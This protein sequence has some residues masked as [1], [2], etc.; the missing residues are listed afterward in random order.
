MTSPRILPAFAALALFASLALPPVLARAAQPDGLHSFAELYRLSV[1]ADY[2]VTEAAAAP[3]P[4]G[5]VPVSFALPQDR[6]PEPS[7][8]AGASV[9]PHKASEGAYVFSTGAWPR[10]GRWL[11]LLSG[12]ALAAWVARRRLGYSL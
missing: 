11:L 9:P 8:S 3:R 12:L 7:A 5:R 10:P 6:L 4:A 2:A 1:G